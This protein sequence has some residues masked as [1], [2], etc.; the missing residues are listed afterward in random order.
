MNKLVH[1]MVLQSGLKMQ[2]SDILGVNEAALVNHKYIWIS[3]D[4]SEETRE[5]CYAIL[6][7]LAHYHIYLRRNQ[8]LQSFYETSRIMYNRGY[9]SRI[10]IILW[11]EA[12]AWMNTYKLLKQNSFDMRGYLKYALTGW[13]SYFAWVEKR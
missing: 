12:L 13:I 7:E 3:N 11:D 5:Y 10:P 9:K 8:R 1:E 6:H 4:F 2:R